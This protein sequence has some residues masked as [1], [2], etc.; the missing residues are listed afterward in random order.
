[1]GYEQF[2]VQQRTVRLWAVLRSALYI[3]RDSQQVFSTS[4]V[5]APFQQVLCSRLVSAAIDDAIRVG[6]GVQQHLELLCRVGTWVLGGPKVNPVLRP[7]V[8]W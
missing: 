4:L 7:A 2:H 1:M 5:N 8:H 6:A 3:L